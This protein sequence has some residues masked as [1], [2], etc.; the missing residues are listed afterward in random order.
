VANPSSPKAQQMLCELCE[1]KVSLYTVHHLVPR[2]RD[3]KIQKVAILCKACHGM[4]HRLISNLELEK[5]Y[6][7]IELLKEHPEVNRFIR[8]VRKQDPHK[9][10]KIK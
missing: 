9:R 8:W 2:S 6:Y 4:V 1:R 5:N 10:I 7:S 3:N